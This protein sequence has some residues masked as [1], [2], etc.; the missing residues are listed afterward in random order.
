MFGGT[1][2]ETTVSSPNSTR[3]ETSS[4]KVVV[5]NVDAFDMRMLRWD[6]LGA[7]PRRMSVARAITGGWGEGADVLCAACASG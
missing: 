5:D 7:L 3:K 6:C 2:S 4:T 1:K